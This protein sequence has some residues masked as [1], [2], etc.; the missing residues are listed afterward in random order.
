MIKTCPGC[1]GRMKVISVDCTCAY[2]KVWCSEC[3]L[4]VEQRINED[5]VRLVRESLNGA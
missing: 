1:Q 2:V 4:T 3:C 5:Q